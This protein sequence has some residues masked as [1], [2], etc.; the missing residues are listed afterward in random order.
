MSRSLIERLR[1]ARSFAHNGGYRV[2]GLDRDIFAD[3]KEVKYTVHYCLI[4]IAEA[5]K[6]VPADVL[7]LEASIPWESIVGM[8]NRLVHTY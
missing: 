4:G 5:L 3:I 8:R 1:D 6:D 7:A 2:L